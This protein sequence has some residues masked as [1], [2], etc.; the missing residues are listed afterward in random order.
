MNSLTR[1]VIVFLILTVAAVW[2]VVSTFKTDFLTLIHDFSLR[3]PDSVLFIGDVMLAR[4][5]EKN[6]KEHGTE[7]QFNEVDEFHAASRYVFANFEAAVPETHLPTPDLTFQFSVNKEYLPILSG[8]HITHVSLANNHAYDH[9]V[10]GYNHSFAALGASGVIPFGNPRAVTASS[11]VEFVL[12]DVRVGVLGLH[13]V[14][15]GP[16]RDDVRAALSAL[17][18][19]TD[20]QIAYVH[21]GTEYTHTHS[22]SQEEYARFLID[23]GVDAIIGHHPHVIQDVALIEGV[24]VFYSLGNYVFDQF[25]SDDVTTGLTVRVT[26]EKNRVTYELIPIRIDRTVPRLANEEETRSIR[27]EIAGYSEVPLQSSLIEGVIRLE[28]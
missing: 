17:S 6:I 16:S 25:W 7:S 1:I 26:P 28:R 21:W 15:T 8:A 18:S 12:N 14:W 3:T 9:G 5:V 13:S 23:N 27:A 20:I 11:T 2:V 19:T 4:S 22:S 10:D 24:P